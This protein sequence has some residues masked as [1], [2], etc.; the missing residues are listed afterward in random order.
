MF[1]DLDV[2]SG[3]T[4]EQALALVRRIEPDVVL[5][6]LGAARQ[7]AVAAAEPG[8]A[9]PDPAALARIPRSSP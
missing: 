3:E 8:A 2:T 7:P 9:A 1:S 4:S 5:F 6:D